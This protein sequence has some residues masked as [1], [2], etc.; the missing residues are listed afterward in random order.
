MI[1]IQ[2]QDYYFGAALS[3]FFTQ[4]KDAKPSLIESKE[5]SSR[6]YLMISDTSPTFY[7]YM[8][9][10]VGTSV[11]KDGSLS[12][13]FTFT[14]KE[15]QIIQQYID[16]NHKTYVALLCSE[17]EF[18]NTHIAVLT[19]NEYIRACAENDTITVKL[20]KHDKQF[21]HTFSIISNQKRLFSIKRN[22]FEGKITDI[23]DA[24]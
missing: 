21:K 23:V 7:L 15:K 11:S 12:W 10:R 5:E 4:N 24:K 6:S 14:P 18:F 22:R 16:N 9:Y 8:K 20:E 1:K 17:K 19:Q 2:K 3:V 13:S